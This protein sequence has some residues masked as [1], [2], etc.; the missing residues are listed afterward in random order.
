MKTNIK[1]SSGKPVVSVEQQMKAIRV[2][3]GMFFK[4]TR[5]N[6]RFS[7]ETFTILVAQVNCKENNLQL[8]VLDTANR[9]T[10]SYYSRE[11]AV[12]EAINGDSDNY[13]YSDFVVFTE[14]EIN[15]K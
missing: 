6:S 10:D 13:E 7:S 2:Y 15:L 5:T 4:F 12:W 8:I 11:T 1:V 14:V 9:F 3:Q